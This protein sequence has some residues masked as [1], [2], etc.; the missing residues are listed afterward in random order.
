MSKTVLIILHKD[1]I[2]YDVASIANISADAYEE[3][4]DHIKHLLQ[5]ICEGE[6]LYRT[7]RYLNLAY[8]HCVNLLR[9]YTHADVSDFSTLDNTAGAPATYTMRLL[10]PDNFD[11]GQVAYLKNLIH[12]Y[13]VW[14]I[15]TEWLRITLPTALDAVATKSAEL[16]AL[17]RKTMDGSGKVGRIKLYPPSGV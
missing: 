8:Q 15:W 14:Y 1:E 9:Q 13:I 2:L 10:V 16:E 5:D 11:K 12:S 17:I 6:N 4:T 3:A 7:Y